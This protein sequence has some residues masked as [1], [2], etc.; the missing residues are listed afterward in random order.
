MDNLWATGLLCLS[1]ATL[2]VEGVSRL[3][4]GT[5]H[6]SLKFEEKCEKM[7][8]LSRVYIEEDQLMLEEHYCQTT[9]IDQDLKSRSGLCFT[10]VTTKRL[11]TIG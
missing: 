2:L 9:D 5:G 7:S 11:R 3:F 4:L 6:L 10:P 8:D 1:L